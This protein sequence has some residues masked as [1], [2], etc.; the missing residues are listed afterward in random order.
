ML[1]PNIAFEQRAVI[2]FTKQIEISI[3]TS[4]M[5][6]YTKERI[7]EEYSQTSTTRTV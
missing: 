3:W 2:E 5:S 6:L 7:N 1:S 4:R